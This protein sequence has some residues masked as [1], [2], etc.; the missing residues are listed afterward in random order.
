MLVYRKRLECHPI[1]TAESNGASNIHWG[2]LVKIITLGTSHGDPTHSR[3]NSATVFEVDQHLYL[4]DA[5]APVNALMIRNK[6]PLQNLKAVFITHL[7]EDH[8]GGLSGLIKSLV[9]YPAADQHTTFLLPEEAA[10]GALLGWM[11]AMH[12]EWNPQLLSFGVTTPGPTY[13]DGKINVT[14]IPTA[15]YENEKKPFPS[16]AYRVTA[17]AKKFLHTGD[18]KWDF[19]DFPQE[20]RHEAF[21]ACICECTHFDVRIVQNILKKCNVKRMIFNHVGNQ[22]H[23]DGEKRFLDIVSELPFPCAIAHDGEGF[24]I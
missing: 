7:H 24:E 23:G 13:Q 18:L 11:G 4:I 1:T 2:K 16:Y 19:S 17:G 10:I 20:A 14:A 9:K 22:W 8:V 12:R 5:G 3:F 6:L 21:D 15:H